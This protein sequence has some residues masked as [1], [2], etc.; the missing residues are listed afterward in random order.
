MERLIKIE[1]FFIIKATQLDEIASTLNLNFTR[2]NDT[3][4]LTLVMLNI[5]AYLVIYLFI[6]LAIRIKR[7]IFKRRRFY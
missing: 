1:N 2:S 3:Y 6:K 4:L 7:K 5:F